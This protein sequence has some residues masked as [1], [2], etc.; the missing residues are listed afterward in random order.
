MG[1]LDDEAPYCKRCEHELERQRDT[2]PR[3][4]YSPKNEGLRVALGFLLVVVLSVS[5]MMIL[6]NLGTLLVPVAA[7]AFL[8]SLVT[9]AVSFLATP[10]RLG[11]LFLRL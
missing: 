3:C 11:S 4:Q 7:L 9:F 5:V 8:L 6:P 2:C 1:L 10:Y